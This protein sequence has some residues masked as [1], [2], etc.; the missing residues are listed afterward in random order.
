MVYWISVFREVIMKVTAQTREKYQVEISTGQ[1]TFLADEP[2]GVGDDAGPDPYSLL[3]SALGSCMV[4]TLHM[5]ANRKEWPLEKV[6][7]SLNTYRS[8]V[9]DCETCEGDPDARISIIETEVKFEGNLDQDQISRLLEIAERCP[10]H[11]TLSGQI[12]I[13]TKL[14]RDQI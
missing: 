1:H 4:I 9:R 11:R 8:H 10:V 13:Q 3:L 14:S 12:A 2:L 6:Y 5:Y 7:V